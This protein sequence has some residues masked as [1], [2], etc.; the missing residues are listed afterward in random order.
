M[1]NGI[2]EVRQIALYE[3]DEVS[4]KETLKSRYQGIV[5]NSIRIVEAR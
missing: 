3:L 1:N 2:Y 5:E 4:A